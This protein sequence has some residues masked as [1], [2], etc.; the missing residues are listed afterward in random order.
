MGLRE[1]KTG[2]VIR[3]AAGFPAIFVGVIMSGFPIGCEVPPPPYVPKG[4]IAPKVV[5]CNDHTGHK[6]G[7]K[8][9][10]MDGTC[11]CTPSEELI[12][13]LHADGFCTGMT[14][15]DLG[16]MYEKAGIKLRGE[17]HMWCNGM[18]DAGPHVVLGGKCMCPPT[19]GTEYYERVVSGKR[20]VATNAKTLAAK[21]P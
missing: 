3:K 7:A 21:K 10:I 8:P 6:P 19:P 13:K 4:L 15:G 9:W 14:A 17:G 5:C 11:T 2:C 1:L 20:P 18:C 16:A 12:G